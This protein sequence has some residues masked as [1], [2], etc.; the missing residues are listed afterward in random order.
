MVKYNNSKADDFLNL[1]EHRSIS[2]K[3][4]KEYNT[5]KNRTDREMIKSRDSIKNG[6]WMI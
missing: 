1:L 3:R 6:V 4:F 2:T 5:R